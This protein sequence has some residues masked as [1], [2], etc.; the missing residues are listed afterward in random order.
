MSETGTAII[1]MSV[2]R[3]FCR[4][5]KTTRMTRTIASTSVCTISLM[6]SVT[7]SVVSSAYDVV[8][9]VREA[10][11]A[12]PSIVFLTP[13]ATA[14]AFEPGRLEDGDAGAGLAVQ[15]RAT[16]GS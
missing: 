15:A 1:G 16:A 5:R 7:G 9:V 12:A 14:S 6:P 3:Q 8:E 2:A 11:L 13:S 10:L 4:K